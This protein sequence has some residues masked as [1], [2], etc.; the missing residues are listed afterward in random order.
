MFAGRSSRSEAVTSRRRPD[1][2]ASTIADSFN[3]EIICAVTESRGTSPTVGLAFVNITTTEAILCQIVDT[4]TY[5]RSLHKL[6][7]LEPSTILFSSTA[8]FPTKSK[9]FSI[10]EDNIIGP[11]IVSLDRKYWNETSGI[12]YVQNLAFGEDVEAIKVSLGGNYF[13][14]CCFAAVGVRFC[15]LFIYTEKFF[16]RP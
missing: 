11:T 9:L 14:T 3:H 5:V 12:D 16:F 2:A 7:V 6:Q 13:A 10:V 4:Q 8:L 1:T 15:G